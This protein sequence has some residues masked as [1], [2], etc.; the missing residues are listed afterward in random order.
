[1]TGS[2]DA[3][4]TEPYLTGVAEILADVLEIQAPEVSM[5]SELE[6]FELDSVTIVELIMRLERRFG[7]V[8]QARRLRGMTHVRELVALLDELVQARTAAARSGTG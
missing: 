7:V 8:I 3:R 1:M 4:R 6:D 2:E 5:D